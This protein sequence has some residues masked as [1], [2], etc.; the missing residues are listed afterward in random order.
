M[1]EYLFQSANKANDTIDGATL[2]IHHYQSDF[3][4]FYCLDA[5]FQ[6][7]FEYCSGLS[8][9]DYFN[10]A[11]LSP[12]EST[13]ST[14]SMQHYLSFNTKRP[15]HHHDFYEL[16]LVLEGNVIHQIEEKEY[17]YRTGTSCL[18]N[19]N[20]RH[21][22]KFIGPAKL[23]FIGLS[24]MFVTELLD[25][26]KTNCFKEEELMIHDTVLQF[27]KSDMSSS[28]AKEYLD[29]FPVFQ[30]R[31]S[32]TKIHKIADS[33]MNT[34]LSPQFGSTYITKG[35]ICVLIQYLSEKGNYH[36]T[37]VR[38][39]SREDFLLFSRA[40]HILEDTDGRISRQE[41]EYALNYSGDY[42]N[43]IIKKYT[44]M[45][46][47]DYSMTFCLKKA[48]SLLTT[49]DDTIA[50]IMGQLHFSNSTHFYKLFKKQFGITPKEYRMA[51]EINVN[52]L[53]SN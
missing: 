30:N 37:H 43:R 23:M 49:T 4:S 31:E 26:Y 2:K 51:S 22:E 53:C 18:I 46:L 29:F 45:C 33:L 34:V 28:A 47:F 9:D 3:D 6:I 36:I 14:L 21:A 25:S 12:K 8:P 44:G 10:I 24:T 5:A 13:F 16:M 32:V 38:L 50:S 7:T 39:N 15:L 11:T 41:L 27:M 48:A 20:V 19:R 40:T 42:I 52:I 35:N 1:E 17:L